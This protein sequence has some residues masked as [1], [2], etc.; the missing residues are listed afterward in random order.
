[1]ISLTLADEVSITD[2]VD[3]D[4]ACEAFGDKGGLFFS[5]GAKQIRFL[6]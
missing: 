5:A 1:M 2:S 6:F 3:N 4:G